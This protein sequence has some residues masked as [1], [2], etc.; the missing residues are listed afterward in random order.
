MKDQPFILGVNYWPQKTALFMWR[1]FD[2][3]SIDEDM[4]LISGL[5]LSCVRIFL[6][7]EDFQPKPKNVPTVM[8]D[9]LAELLEI[10]DDRN[11]AVVVTLFTGH[12]FGLNCLPPWMLLA[13]TEQGQYQVFS[14]DKLRFNKMRNPYAEPE[15]IEGQ[16]YF[17]RELTS[18]VS[19]HP[20]LYSW[21]LGNEPSLWSVPPDSFSAE[22]WLQA[23]TETLKEEDDTLPLTLSL[24]VNDLTRSSGLTPKLA[25]KYLD[26]LAI[27]VKPH[28]IPW[29]KDPFSPAIPSFLGSVA[30]WLGKSSVMIE[31][32]G[33][34]TEP[35]VPVAGGRDPGSE[36]AH[37][38]V[39]EEDAALYAENAL[40]HLRRFD[41]MGAFWKSYGDYHPSIW[42][43]PPLAWS[44]TERFSGIVRYDGTPKM[45]ASVF[46]P[47]STGSEAEEVS[48]EWI[49]VSEEEYYRDPGQHL[50][51]LYG[52]FREYYSFA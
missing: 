38:L 39:S 17:L 47:E 27:S 7:W 43:W 18:A 51:R 6:L 40:F 30:R 32:F 48:F 20:A 11:L 29:A 44:K 28:R 9:R 36:D 50:G 16:I 1:E 21:D 26:Y 49:D 23:M 42:K 2:R 4:S 33:L 10:A 5:G 8:L 46:K 41:L 15:I 34:A 14:M 37:L 24:H 52:R 22:L 19:G 35:F 12:I 31:E 3:A 45:A 13:S 25:A